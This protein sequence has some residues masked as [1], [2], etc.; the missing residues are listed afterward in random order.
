MKRLILIASVAFSLSYSVFAN[1]PAT[2]E[3]SKKMPP[4]VGVLS[5]R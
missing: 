4:L 5:I 1:A 2:D 3:N